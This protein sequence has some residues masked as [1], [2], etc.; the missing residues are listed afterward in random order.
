MCNK[1]CLLC[2]NLEEFQSL[3]CEEPVS[4]SDEVHSLLLD[5]A[6]PDSRTAE[7]P[8]P[9]PPVYD[10][11][12]RSTGIASTV[13]SQ[14]DFVARAPHLHQ[15][16]SSGA[17]AFGVSYSTSG[18]TNYRNTD[19]NK[20][21]LGSIQPPVNMSFFPADLQHYSSPFHTENTTTASHG[22][23]F[24]TEQ[25]QNTLFPMTA[26]DRN[27]YHPFPGSANPAVARNKLPTAP[28]VQNSTEPYE[29]F[30]SQTRTEDT[31][32]VEPFTPYSADDGS[33]HGIHRQLLSNDVALPLASVF[34][35]YIPDT[36]LHVPSAGIIGERKP[37]GFVPA[38]KGTTCQ[39]K[40]E[41]VT[42]AEDVGQLGQDIAAKS[43]PTTTARV[44]PSST[45]STHPQ[46][47]VSHSVAETNNPDTR[48]TETAEESRTNKATERPPFVPAY[49]PSTVWPIPPYPGAPFP[50]PF[51]PPW[52]Y[53]P[54]MPMMPMSVMPHPMMVP[55]PCWMPPMH[56][57]IRLQPP[58][59]QTPAA[60][61]Y[62]KLEVD[63]EK[64]P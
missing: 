34:D 21:L 31:A 40:E 38:V 42:K 37:I 51:Y 46:P 36:G 10:S 32:N 62:E 27:F 41:S 3:R 35:R 33:K 64:K 55:V 13:L 30:T 28:A 18:S 23:T 47:A 50:Y 52:P 22:D 15:N 43:K 8:N 24:Y 49:A 25:H 45:V 29:H 48:D 56:P 61:A 6:E 26:T 11:N 59:V 57:A 7:Q 63:S 9:Q 4:T 12:A 19:T 17:N 14:L 44:Q 1:T 54:P 39:N 58:T 53:C 5:Q 60:D 16:A 2:R 20:D